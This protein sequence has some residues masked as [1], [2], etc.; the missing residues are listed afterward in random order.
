VIGSKVRDIV[1]DADKLEAIGEAGI[2]RCLEYQIHKYKEDSPNQ[3]IPHSQLIKQVVEHAHEKLL[4][5]REHFFRTKI[6]KEISL[7]LHNEMEILVRK[8]EKEQ[9]FPSHFF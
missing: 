7:P 1:S 4:R 2:K 6:G 8:I 3:E 9:C 5:L